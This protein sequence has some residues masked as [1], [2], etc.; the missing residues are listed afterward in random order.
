VGYQAGEKIAIKPNLNNT[1]RADAPTVAWND[2][3]QYISN[4]NSADVTPQTITALLHQLG[5]ASQ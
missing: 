3:N 4:H 5:P 2:P 1:R